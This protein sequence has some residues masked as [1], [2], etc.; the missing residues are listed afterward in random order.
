[1]QPVK[2]MGKMLSFWISEQ[3]YT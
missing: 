1:M 3:R 2:T